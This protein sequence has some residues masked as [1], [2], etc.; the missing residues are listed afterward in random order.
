MTAAGQTRAYTW[1]SCTHGKGRLCA[2]ATATNTSSY[3]YTPEG[4]LVGRTFAFS[5][6]ANYSLGYGYDAMGH[7]AMVTY[8]DGNQ[9]LYD[10]SYGAVADVRLKV[11]SN[12]VYG[13]TA[14]GYRPMDLAMSGWT[15]Y[16]GLTN[17]ITYDSDLRPVSRGSGSGLSS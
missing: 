10:H 8:P 6:G 5:S 16:G 4:W 9:A 13:I 3:S 15:S 1:D 12:T 11:G 17:A 2:A 7:L 14:I